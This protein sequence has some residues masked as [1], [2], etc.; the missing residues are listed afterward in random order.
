M[1][2]RSRG[3]RPEVELHIDIRWLLERQAEVLPK[4][5]SV[6]D[7]SNLVAAVARHR[8]NTPQVGVT[9]DNAWRAAALMHAIIRLRPLPARNAL[10]GA[11]VVTAYMDAASEAVD[12]PYGALI[13]LARD[14]D[15]GR[16]D[17]YDAADRIR[18]W[19]I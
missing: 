13:D 5:P 18:S 19:R 1:L 6:H 11:A 10:Y 3:G 15:A 17:G 14:I 2:L 7:F 8:V 9:V 12:P 4:Q 16:A